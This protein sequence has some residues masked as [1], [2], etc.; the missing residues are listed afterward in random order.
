MNVAFGES[1]RRLFAPWLSLLVLLGCVSESTQRVD[2]IQVQATVDGMRPAD[3]STAGPLVVG[4]S[5]LPSDSARGARPV[6][7]IQDPQA[8]TRSELEAHLRG[9]FGP[10]IVIGPDG[11]ITKQYFLV[12]EL[13][14]TFLKLIHEIRPEQPLPIVE[15]GKPVVPPA[16]GTKVGG[17]G[18]RS[19][20]G[21]MLRGREIE[22]TYLPDFEKLSGARIADPPSPSQGSAVTGAPMQ[23]DVTNSTPVAL[24]LVTATSAGLTAFEGALDLFYTSI[25]QIEITVQ[26]IEYT[27]ADALAFGVTGID[28]NTPKIDNLSSGALVQ[29]YTSIFPL[30]QPVVGASPV[31][32]VGL[33]TLGG[34]HDSWELNVILQALEANN[35]ADITSSPKLVVRNGGVASISTLT[36][37]PF[38][39][40]R[41]NQG[42]NAVTA[43]IEFKPVG[44][45]MNIIPVIAGKDTVLL[46]LYA[47]VSAVTGFAN[48]TPVVTPITSQRSAV[49][50]VYL[51]H[52]HSLLIGGLKSVTSFQSE[53]KVPILGDIPLLGFLFRSTSTSRQETS[54]AFQITPRIVNDRGSPTERER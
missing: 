22:I 49:T 3:A 45:K 53:T 44:V 9:L 38:P 30:R 33:F 14:P 40:A 4:L 35:V 19:I 7:A 52:N 16:P 48:T 8:Q 27:N 34:I 1:M 12:G 13:G 25:P 6:D 10:S 37:I 51:K 46:Q 24:L 36:Q 20:L 32:D 21:Q 39:K 5:G 41:I 47:D 2:P 31:T 28:A 29:A 11:R 23:V 43:D 54:V 18:S 17:E 42:I 15:P 26:V 50:T